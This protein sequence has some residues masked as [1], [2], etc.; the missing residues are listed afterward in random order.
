MLYSYFYRIDE[1]MGD[2]DMG[3]VHTILRD[4]GQTLWDMAEALWYIDYDD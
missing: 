4:L 1:I 2:D 3:V